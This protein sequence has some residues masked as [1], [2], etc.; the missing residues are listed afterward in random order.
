MGKSPEAGKNFSL[1]ASPFIPAGQLPAAPGAIVYSDIGL[2]AVMDDDAEFSPGLLMK[3]QPVRAV[4]GGCMYVTVI[5]CMVSHTFTAN[6]FFQPLTPFRIEKN[7]CRLFPLQ[8]S[9]FLPDFPLNLPYNIRVK[10][11]LIK[12]TITTKGVKPCTSSVY[13]GLST[14]SSLLPSGMMR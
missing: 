4:K 6:S 7:L 5:A 2:S 14:T 3:N 10:I 13:T 11:A 12:S 8:R 9:V 1:D